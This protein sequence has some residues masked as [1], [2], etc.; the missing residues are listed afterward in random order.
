M[1]EFND[2]KRRFD[3]S[4]KTI[5]LV[6]TVTISLTLGLFRN[7][8]G[9]KFFL[10]TFFPFVFSLFIWVASNI[11]DG[12]FEYLIKLIAWHILIYDIVV[13]FARISLGQLTLPPS[14]GCIIIF[15]TLIPTFLIKVWLQEAE[16][17]PPEAPFT[18]YFLIII[19][20]WTVYQISLL[21]A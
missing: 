21:I 3:E 2:K 8:L 5:L 7:A 17:I 12:P 11:C 18:R 19:G 1:E 9:I 13:S 10:D 6:V 14:L 4:F 15:A 16:V 20:T